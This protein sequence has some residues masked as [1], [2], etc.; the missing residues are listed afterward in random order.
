[1]CVF[2]GD[3]EGDK[4]HTARCGE[5]I[6]WMTDDVAKDTIHK[7]HLG[8]NYDFGAQIETNPNAYHVNIFGNRDGNKLRFITEF[9]GANYVE[10]LGA[11]P[12]LT[13]D[14]LGGWKDY[15]AAL[16]D[17]HADTCASEALLHRDFSG[18]KAA[19]VVKL[20]M[21]CKAT[22]G[23]DAYRTGDLANY[24]NG[25]D[26]HFSPGIALGLLQKATEASE[27][28]CKDAL[29]VAWEIGTAYLKQAKLARETLEAALEMRA[30]S[31]AK[32][33]VG[34]ISEYVRKFKEFVIREYAHKTAMV[35]ARR[36]LT[37]LARNLVVQAF[38]PSGI[39]RW[40]KEEVVPRLIKSSL[41]HVKKVSL[42]GGGNAYVAAMHSGLHAHMYSDD[43]KLMDSKPSSVVGM[44]PSGLVHNELVKWQSWL[45]ATVCNSKCEPP[46]TKPLSPCQVH[47][48]SGALQEDFSRLVSNVADKM[49]AR[50]NSMR[51]L[52][53]LAGGGS[54][55][56]GDAKYLQGL[57][58]TGPACGADAKQRLVLPGKIDYAKEQMVWMCGHCPRPFVE[59]C[60]H[61]DENNNSSIT[62]IDTQYFRPSVCASVVTNDEKVI[63]HAKD[64]YAML[65]EMRVERAELESA[66][67]MDRSKTFISEFYDFGTWIAHTLSC[68]SPYQDYANT[69]NK[70]PSRNIKR[71]RPFALLPDYVKLKHLCTV[72]SGSPAYYG[73]RLM[74]KDCDGNPF[75]ARVT[76]IKPPR[77][78]RTMALL[79]P[80]PKGSCWSELAGDEALDTISAGVFCFIGP[81]LSANMPTLVCCDVMPFYGKEVAQGNWSCAQFNTNEW[82]YK[83]DTPINVEH[84][85]ELQVFKYEC[86]YVTSA[87]HDTMLRKKPT[88]DFLMG[89]LSGV[90]GSESAAGSS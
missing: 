87:L 43:D 65:D 88:A 77:A 3:T 23:T 66:V 75:V 6:A 84:G 16:A 49:D 64:Y 72:W 79:V 86:S 70:D 46:Y 26:E 21:M 25:N 67:L 44:L 30:L 42:H 85:A 80:E 32:P 20:A 47:E 11:K 37:V 7:T 55:P 82:F 74:L 81:A 45:R 76:Y 62:R 1:V 48:W 36:Q 69:Y 4:A 5:I 54:A 39:V 59:T 53:H 63:Q 61:K 38:E 52:T 60:V 10:A 33:G 14:R 2:Q 83:H 68:D 8:D 24:G 22:L 90:S 73:P 28:Q 27:D 13:E 56:L 12:L 71:D 9:D 51:V 57:L 89:I 34:T 29:K 50:D 58:Y 35:S 15:T 41:V 18:G 78:F 40:A 31:D 19:L 17:L